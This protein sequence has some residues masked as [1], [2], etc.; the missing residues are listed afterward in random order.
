[1]NARQSTVVAFAILSGTIIPVAGSAA[2]QQ[3]TTVEVAFRQAAVLPD[4]SSLL[5]LEYD[6]TR[7]PA[8][9]YC[10]SAGDATALFRLSSPGLEPKLVSLSLSTDSTGSKRVVAA[11]RLR[12][13]LTGLQPRPLQRGR[14]E[15]SEYR[16]QVLLLPQ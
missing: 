5:F 12:L 8:D 15:P 4:G 9:V 13:L 7:C 1:M 3:A 10:I 16:A 14:V 11:G 6:D 2:E